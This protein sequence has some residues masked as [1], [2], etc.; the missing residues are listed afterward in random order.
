MKQDEILQ[1]IEKIDTFGGT[2]YGCYPVQT[3]GG[4]FLKKLE[5]SNLW[6]KSSHTSHFDKRNDNQVDIYRGSDFLFTKKDS[7]KKI[8]VYMSS[9]RSGKT[10]TWSFRCTFSEPIE[11]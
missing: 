5:S 11:F 1:V 6:E 7:D 3:E 9:S 10:Q 8:Y 2:N 4:Q